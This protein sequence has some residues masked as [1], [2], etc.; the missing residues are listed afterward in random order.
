MNFGSP[1][2]PHRH[3]RFYSCIL[4]RIDVILLFSVFQKN[5]D[6]ININACYFRETWLQVLSTFCYVPGLAF[7]NWRGF[8]SSIEG[9]HRGRNFSKYHSSWASCLTNSEIRVDSIRLLEEERWSKF[10][11]D[12]FKQWPCW[13]RAWSLASRGPHVQ[14]ISKLEGSPPG[15]EGRPGFEIFLSHFYRGLA[16]REPLVVM[17]RKFQ[18]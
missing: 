9:R 10:L 14:R 8:Q 12:S 18:N 7:G 16:W 13:R 5:E 3:Q 2:C 15:V 17:C 11:Y 4:M 1:F 6:N